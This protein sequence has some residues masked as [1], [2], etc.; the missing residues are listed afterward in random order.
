M[1]YFFFFKG[2]RKRNL[3]WWNVRN[4]GLVSGNADTTKRW[5]A[6]RKAKTFKTSNNRVPPNTPN[7]GSRKT[8]SRNGKAWVYKNWPQYFDFKW[9]MNHNYG[10]FCFKAYYL[11][12]ATHECWLKHKSHVTTDRK[13]GQKFALPLKINGLSAACKDNS[14]I[15][16]CSQLLS[17]L[18][19][20]RDLVRK[21]SVH[22]CLVERSVFLCVSV[23]QRMHILFTSMWLASSSQTFPCKKTLLYQSIPDQVWFLQLKLLPLQPCHNKYITFSPAS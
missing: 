11:F 12:C 9:K 13:T 20:S 5:Q 22:W 10:E 14:S 3:A 4:G 2:K 6:I 23:G 19:E 21:G 18:R 1:I 7:L 17:F 8:A 15:C 16:V